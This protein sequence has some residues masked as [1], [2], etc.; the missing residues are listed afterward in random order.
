[1]KIEIKD[2]RFEVG[3]IKTLL[4]Q[5]SFELELMVDAKQAFSVWSHKTFFT[6]TPLTKLFILMI[7]TC[8]MFANLY[9][10]L[11]Y[12]VKKGYSYFALF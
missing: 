1:M 4:N 7:L 11:R 12:L 10:K 2:R 3:L 8:R 5:S 6:L 9:I